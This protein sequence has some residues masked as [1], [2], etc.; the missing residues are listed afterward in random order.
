MNARKLLQFALVLVMGFALSGCA[1]ISAKNYSAVTP[2]WPLSV[3]G[4]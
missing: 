2:D 4:P 1:G 3:I